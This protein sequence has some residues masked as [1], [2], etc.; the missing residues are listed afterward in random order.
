M[1]QSVLYVSSI[2]FSSFFE[3]RRKIVGKMSKLNLHQNTFESTSRD[4]YLA[5]SVTACI[6]PFCLIPIF[7][8]VVVLLYLLSASFFPVITGKQQL[9]DRF[10]NWTHF[11]RSKTRGTKT[12]FETIWVEC[13]LIEFLS[14]WFCSARPKSHFIGSNS[15]SCE[16]NFYRIVNFK[17]WIT[18]LKTFFRHF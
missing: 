7:I 3:N 14:F 6:F 9:L 1:H 10:G 15:K 16:Y 4:Y 12:L 11:S 8:E 5:K 13:L 17:L 18:L 2:S